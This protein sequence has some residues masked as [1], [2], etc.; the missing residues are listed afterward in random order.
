MTLAPPELGAGGPRY[1]DT[2]GE[3]LLNTATFA[4]PLQSPNSDAA[5]E[6]LVNIATFAGPLNPPILGDFERILT[7]DWGL[8]GLKNPNLIANVSKC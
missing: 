3:I 6:I 2:A 4:G 1:S 5:G 7:L 8:G